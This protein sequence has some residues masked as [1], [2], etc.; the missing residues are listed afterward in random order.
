MGY[1]PGLAWT[2]YNQGLAFHRRDTITKAPSFLLFWS[3]PQSIVVPIM[4]YVDAMH[5][6]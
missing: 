6:T 4:I 3:T 5:K 2:R 1:A